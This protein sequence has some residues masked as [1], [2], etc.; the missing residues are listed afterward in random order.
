MSHVFKENAEQLLWVPPSFPYYKP[1]G[2]Y[3]NTENFSKTLVFSSWEMVPRMLAGLLSYEAER[4]TVGILARNH[5]DKDP[6]G[7]STGSA[8]AVSAGTVSAQAARMSSREKPQSTCQVRYMACS[9]SEGAR[10][11]PRPWTSSALL[12]LPIPSWH[13]WN[14]RRN[15]RKTS[16]WKNAWQ[17]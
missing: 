13:R 5:P 7:S 10:R 14:S 2:V 9:S 11:L 4:R 1:Q 17:S 8:V 3:K 6:S 16:G 15:I 12:A